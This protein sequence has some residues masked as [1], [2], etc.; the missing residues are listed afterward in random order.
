[1]ESMEEFVAHVTES[2][3]AP[4]HSATLD[5][6][7]FLRRRVPARSLDQQAPT[8][9]P[10]AIVHPSAELGRRVRVGPY[11]IVGPDVVLE[12]GVCLMAHVVV[13]GS[14]RVGRD[15]TVYP[16]ACLGGE[17]QDKKH[18]VFLDQQ[19]PPLPPSLASA[20]VIGRNC[21]I[22]E[23]ATIHGSTAYSPDSPTTVG[24]DC[25]VLCGAHIGHDVRVG[26]RVV[27]SNNVC[28]AGHV[29]IGDFAIIG[30]QVG[31]KQHVKVG[32]LAMIG[33]QSAVD[34]DVLPYGLVVG[35][36]AKLAGLNLIGLRRARV[37]R[38]N[39]KLMLRVYR[40]LFGTSTSCSKTGFAP[41]LECVCVTAG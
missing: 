10:S 33:G 28:V 21:V 14:T 30:G 34:G 5:T 40:Y 3:G 27:I 38:D 19:D 1:M 23:H 31:L 15:T 8:I 36:R 29:H 20:L 13:D 17:P 18:R 41:P 16:F 26:N 25:W 11:S 32:S 2:M 22:R 37:S 39:I 7:E 35:N 6:H 24:D 12:D 4:R 9:H